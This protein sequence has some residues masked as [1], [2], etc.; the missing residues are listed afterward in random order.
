MGESTEMELGEPGNRIASGF[1]K[2][3]FKVRIW[4]QRLCHRTIFRLLKLSSTGPNFRAPSLHF[5]HFSE[6]PASS[7]ELEPPS[8]IPTHPARLLGSSSATIP[9]VVSDHP[10][11]VRSVSPES[12]WPLMAPLSDF[13]SSDPTTLLGY[14]FPLTHTAFRVKS[15]LSPLIWDPIAE[16]PSTMMAPYELSLPYPL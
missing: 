12:P 9:Q 5:F 8:S 10:G 2:L 1:L 11:L 3:L 6:S 7:V 14:K 4:W 16:V 13:P 15:H